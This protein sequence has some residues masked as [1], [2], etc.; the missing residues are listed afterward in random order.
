M[1]E[2]LQPLCLRKKTHF[3]NF[4]CTN[5][6][7]SEKI[8]RKKW[9]LLCMSR[10]LSPNPSLSE[11]MG[12]I[13]SRDLSHDR[14]RA[15]S[16]S[17]V[18]MSKAQPHRTLCVDIL[19][20]FS[21]IF[22]SIRGGNMS[23]F[24]ESDYEKKR[25]I[26]IAT[27]QEMFASL[28]PEGVRSLYPPPLTPSQP[29]I[30]KN[31]VERRQSK[32]P[33]PRRRLPKRQCRSFVGKYD[34]EKGDDEEDIEV[35][36]VRSPNTLRIKLWPS[37]KPKLPSSSGSEDS[38][39]SPK[40]KRPAPKRPPMLP[41]EITE[42]DLILVA[43]R[44]CDKNYDQTNGTSCHQC[45]Q[46]T[47]DLKTVCRSS[48]CIGIRGQFC[49]PCLKNRYGEDAKKALMDLKWQCPPCR[50]ICNCSFCMKKRGRRCTGIMIHL[51]RER[52]FK[53]VKSF[54]GD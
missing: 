34:S 12:S 8:K 38:D 37:R 36:D 2:T 1:I 28:F 33:L 24:E 14:F 32:V 21:Y 23:F 6:I 7:K 17:R 51:A 11:V 27:N 26:A 5:Q 44:V 30:K 53:D 50:G 15:I 47:D 31:N 10:D 48:S 3:L 39:S 35:E 43:E 45:R 4:Y 16:N 22:T 42:D 18:I 19:P 54:L 25:N 49:G 46:K 40:R 13:T 20:S 29:S 41:V 9:F 52:G